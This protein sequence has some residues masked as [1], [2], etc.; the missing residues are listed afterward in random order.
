MLPRSSGGYV[1]AMFGLVVVALSGCGRFGFD[2][3]DDA[4]PGDGLEDG[5]HA[6]GDAAATACGSAITLPL[7][8]AIT[9]DTCATGLDL[10]DGCGPAGT[11][12]VVLAFTAPAFGSYSFR[13]RDPN[14]NVGSIF[15][16]VGAAC[17]G[18]MVCVN[19]LSITLTAGQTIYFVLE[20]SSGSCVTVE[21]E[22]D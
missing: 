8:A 7:A 21:L 10:L 11:Q 12:E 5:A 22:N 18:A 9:I 15:G 4:R 1:T 20:A 17:T 19:N 6:D 14:T 13:A 16:M 2:L 3:L